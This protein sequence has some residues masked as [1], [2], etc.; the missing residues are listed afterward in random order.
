MVKNPPANARDAGSIPRS[1]RYPGK[2]NGNPLM[3]FFPGKS[4]GQRSL[5]GYKPWCCRRIRHDLATKQ[6]LLLIA[7]E[8]SSSSGL[9]ALFPGKEIVL[10][11]AQWPTVPHK[12]LC[13]TGGHDKRQLRDAKHWGKVMYEQVLAP[14]AAHGTFNWEVWVGKSGRGEAHVVHT[15]RLP[16]QM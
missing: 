5:V 8:H 6:Q 14:A 1:G 12:R 15:G 16:C 11:R 10:R 7:R 3:V 2:G 13:A 9:C 4:H